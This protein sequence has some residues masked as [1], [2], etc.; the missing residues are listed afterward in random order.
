MNCLNCTEAWILCQRRSSSTGTATSPL[1]TLGSWTNATIKMK[2]L[3]CSKIPRPRL[4]LL[5]AG[6]LLVSLCSFGQINVVSVAPLRKLT[7]PATG[8][9]DAS[10]SVQLRDG[11]HVNSNMPSDEYF[12]PLRLTWS[13]GPVEAVSVTFPK[14]KMEKLAFSDKPVSIFSGDFDVVTKFKAAAGASLG[15]N[16]VTGK[17]RY[18]ACNDRMCLPPKTIDLSLPVEVTRGGAKP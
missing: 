14:P 1:R 12:I 3:S 17:L 16:V 9:A 15:Q 13:A 5:L 18:Q 8:T 6:T 11:Y 10:V 2:F 4:F 7:V